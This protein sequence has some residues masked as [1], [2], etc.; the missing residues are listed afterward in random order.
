[1]KESLLILILLG[2]FICGYYFIR[3][4]DGFLE[5]NRKAIETESEKKEPSCV[6]LT[7]DL[8]DEEIINELHRFRLK[9]EKVKILLYDSS[10]AQLSES[11]EHRIN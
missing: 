10:D 5:E 1:M 4:L 11:I 9:H 6:M 2:I 8:T 3:K 7:A